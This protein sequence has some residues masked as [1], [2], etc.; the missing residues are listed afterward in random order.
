MLP[1]PIGVQAVVENRPSIHPFNMHTE[2]TEPQHIHRHTRG[3]YY[4]QC[5]VLWWTRRVAQ[6]LHFVLSV[7]GAAALFLSV[8]LAQAIYLSTAYELACVYHHTPY[9]DCMHGTQSS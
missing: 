2:W 1:I 3:A 6:K 7:C 8:S 5:A 9:G 4:I